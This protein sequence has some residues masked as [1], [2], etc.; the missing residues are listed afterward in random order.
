VSSIAH[1]D[2]ILWLW[3]TN[4]YMREAFGVLDAW[5][6]ENKTILTWVKNRIGTGDWLRGQTEH[7]LLAVRGKPTVQLSDQTTALGAPA[8]AHSAKPDAFYEMVEALCPAP[9]YAELF[10]RTPRPN[11]DGHGD[12]V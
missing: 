10:Q 11:W 4:A 2:A 7:C 12:E 3:T 1:D 6:F 8:G 5:G 9:R